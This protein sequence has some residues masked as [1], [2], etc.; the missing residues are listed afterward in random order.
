M[1]DHLLFF[2]YWFLDS[3][4]IYLLALLFPSSI[5]LGNWRLLPVEAAI[6]AGFWLTFFV[7]TM[8]E[9][10]RVRKAALEPNEL[11]FLFFFFVNCLG[12]WLVSRYSQYVGLGI[13]K[14]GWAFLIGAAAYALQKLAWELGGKKLKDSR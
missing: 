13:T 7:W 14:F 6:Y 1:K 11:E 2:V 3:L 5:I 8:W 10:M 4:A 9:F 12:V